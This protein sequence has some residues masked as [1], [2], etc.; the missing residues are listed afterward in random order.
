[1]FSSAD[2]KVTRGQR[3]KQLHKIQ[4][5]LEDL[6]RSVAEGRRLTNAEGVSKRVQKLLGKSAAAKYFHWELVPLTKAERDRWSSPG[7]GCTPPTQ[8][9]V[10]RL[11]QSA[12][13]RDAADDG[14]AVL[15]ATVPAAEG[16]TDELFRKYKQQIHCEHSHHVFK[17]PL[18]VHPVFLKKPERVEALLFLLTIALQA[19]FVLQRRYRA[20]LP[21]EASVK[22]R[23]TTARTLLKTFDNYTLLVEATEHGHH[24]QAT[25]LTPRQREIIQLLHLPTP[26]Q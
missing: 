23:R 12:V 17:G 9:F 16:S 2:Q 11:D 13:D 5:G 15:V 6:A 19:Y 3:E 7:R 20:A 18:A 25:R 26:A 8:R 4:S 14:Y 22:Q 10:F 1:M 24:V 21:A